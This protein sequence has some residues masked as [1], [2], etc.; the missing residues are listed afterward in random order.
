MTF[1][2]L[3]P[4]LSQCFHMMTLWKKSTSFIQ[5]QRE[6]EDGSMPI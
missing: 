1:G 2:R 3:F 5:L 6:K 4:S